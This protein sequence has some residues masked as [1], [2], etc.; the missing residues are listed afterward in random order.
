[1]AYLG[2][3][4]FPR[5]L[6]T[7]LR[8]LGSAADQAR[9]AAVLAEREAERNR[10]RRLLHDNEAVLRLLA[11]PTLDPALAELVRAQAV[12]GA[13][14]VR[15]FLTSPSH[16]VDVG[17]LEQ[18]HLAEVVRAVAAEFGDLPVELAVDLAQGATLDPPMAE[19]VSAAVRT[20]LYN[21]RLHAR[22]TAVTVHA[23]YTGGRWELT[24]R[25]DGVGYDPAVTPAGFG[26]R[27]LVVA[28]LTEQGVSVVVES[29]PGVGTVAVLVGDSSAGG[30]S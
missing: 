12:S 26:L 17:A 1:V 7:Y 15:T 11:D 29:V 18:G 20:L 4:L 3:A 6:A 30:R 10:Q 27:Q 25:D 13:N 24:V 23:D 22:A 14:R 21:V 8:R 19:A 2:F 28:N 5:A 16:G 9:A